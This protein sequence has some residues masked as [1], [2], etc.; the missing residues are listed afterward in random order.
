MLPEDA[1]VYDTL[2]LFLQEVPQDELSDLNAFIQNELLLP[3]LL[4]LPGYHSVRKP[5]FK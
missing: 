3:A 1:V 5:V 4:D 2:I